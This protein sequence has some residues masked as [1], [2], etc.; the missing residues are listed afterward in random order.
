[1]SIYSTEAILLA[2]RNYGEADKIA[3]LFSK[4]F[5]KISALAYGCRRPKSRMAGAM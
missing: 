3:T 2:V 1:M 5:G 4:D